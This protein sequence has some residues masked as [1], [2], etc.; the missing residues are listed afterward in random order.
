MRSDLSME[1]VPNTK[2]YQSP[3]FWKNVSD[4]DSLPSGLHRHCLNEIMDCNVD[5]KVGFKRVCWTPD[6]CDRFHRCFICLDHQ[7]QQRREG[8]KSSRLRKKARGC[9]YITSLAVKYQRNES[10]AS[11]SR[12]LYLDQPLH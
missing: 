10:G 11:R 2:S 6:S 7:E 3:E 4:S 8:I 1:R 9:Q 12:S 5:S